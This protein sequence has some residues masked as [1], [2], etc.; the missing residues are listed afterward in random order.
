MISLANGELQGYLVTEEAVRQRHYEATNAL[1]AS[2][3]AGN[4]LVSV[5]LGLLEGRRGQRGAS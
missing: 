3:E 4:R 5:T 1:F 2:P